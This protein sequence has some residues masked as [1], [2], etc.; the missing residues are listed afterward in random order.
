MSYA[1]IEARVQT[2]LQGLTGTF[3]TNAQVTRGDWSVLDAGYDA[4]AVVYPGAFQQTGFGGAGTVTYVWTVYVDLFQRIGESHSAAIASV[5]AARDAVLQHLQK[6]PKLNALSG[7]YAVQEITGD[8][9]IWLFDKDDN[10][11]FFLKAVLTLPITEEIS[12]TGG[13][14]S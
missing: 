11:P 12:V 10:G 2:L 7:V 13:E 14:I 3:A 6:Y 9:P 5:I 4:M 8:E 1:T